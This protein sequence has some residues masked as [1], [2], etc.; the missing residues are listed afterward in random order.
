MFQA[1]VLCSLHESCKPSRPSLIWRSLH[2][3]PHAAPNNKAWLNLEAGQSCTKSLKQHSC[4]TFDAG[5]L[6]QA[7]LTPLGKNSR[8]LEVV[9]ATKR[10]GYAPKASSFSRVLGLNGI[11]AIRCRRPK[12]ATSIR[13]LHS[14][15]A[16]DDTVQGSV[17]TVNCFPRRM[18][19]KGSAFKVSEVRLCDPKIPMTTLSGP[20]GGLC[21]KLEVHGFFSTSPPCRVHPFPRPASSSGTLLA[22]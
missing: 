12:G 19:A 6:V 1:S 14:W 18:L 16:K 10:G 15:N 22:R 20:E 9:S 5:S 21:N 4:H 13:G 8:H 11:P 2:R 3:K 7:G 17:S